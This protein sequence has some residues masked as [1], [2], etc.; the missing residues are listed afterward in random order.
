MEFVLFLMPPVFVLGGGALLLDRWAD[1]KSRLPVN[2]SALHETSE[3]LTVQAQEHYLLVTTK[4][5]TQMRRGRLQD[6]VAELKNIDGLQVHRSWWVARAAVARVLKRERDYV[7]HLVSG[8]TVPV[9]RS[10][11]AA[12]RNSGWI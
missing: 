7:I 8:E 11:V 6:E 5:G 9:A 2:K 4:E 10:K 1:S 3:I 12:L